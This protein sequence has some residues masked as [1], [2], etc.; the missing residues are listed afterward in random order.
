MAL[1]TELVLYR[2]YEWTEK[3]ESRCRQRN[4]EMI[5]FLGRAGVKANQKLSFERFIVRRDSWA[6]PAVKK[7]VPPASTI[8]AAAVRSLF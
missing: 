6:S 5:L 8:E 4:L 1:D 3:R 7:G 2:K